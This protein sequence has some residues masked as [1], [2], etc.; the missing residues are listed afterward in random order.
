MSAAQLN[1]LR[2]FLRKRR[3]DEDITLETFL[4]CK[5]IIGRWP[6]LSEM[7]KLFP[8][9]DE[10]GTKGP[11]SDSRCLLY[12]G[13]FPLRK[14]HKNDPDPMQGKD[15]IFDKRISHI[16]GFNGT[17]L[18]TLTLK[19]DALFVWI[20]QDAHMIVFACGYNEEDA[21]E[22]IMNTVRDV[23]ATWEMYVPWPGSESATFSKAGLIATTDGAHARESLGRRSNWEELSSV[24]HSSRRR[25]S[26][27]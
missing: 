6:L 20:T 21:V 23:N 12:K 1:A 8:Q 27:K 26:R 7:K 16:I 18:H 13:V 4:V 10:Q 17:M 2:T 25:F 9:A 15:M 22:R 19:N 3:L 24:M 14:R 5:I 11:S